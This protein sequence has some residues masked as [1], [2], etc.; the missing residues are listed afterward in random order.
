M[1]GLEGVA[2]VR[3]ARYTALRSLVG[4]QV[5]RFRQ[6]RLYTN[7]TYLIADQ[8]LTVLTGFLFWIIVAR[9]YTSEHVG[10]AAALISSIMLLANISTLG[11]NFAFLR[12]IPDSKFVSEDVIN[13]GLT[14][15]ALASLMV[16]FVFLAGLP[17]WSRS[18]L[19][20]GDSISLA[21]TLILGTLAWG[22]FTLLDS[23]FVGLRRAIFVPIKNLSSQVLRLF[24]I[25]LAF[26][27]GG[28]GVQGIVSAWTFPVLAVLGI[29]L[30][31]LLPTA[32]RSYKPK[33]SLRFWSDRQTLSFSLLNHTTNLGRLVPG[34]LFVIM[35]VNVVSE[36]AGAYFF[37]AWSISAL[38][39]AVSYSTSNVLLSE[40]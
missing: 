12:F 7:S 35:I 11:F 23:A 40:S 6:Y 37:V 3:N 32:G 21:L 39:M 38:L 8:A 10:L 16:A 36:D 18:L 22:L 4:H 19:F 14:T 1:K 20:I 24:L 17:L 34:Y 25:T 15:V 27:L 9:L 33:L 29:T 28:L 5:G 31:H 2:S 30:F 26:A 13:R